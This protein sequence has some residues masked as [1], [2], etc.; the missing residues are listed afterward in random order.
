M[1]SY[2]TDCKS[3][4]CCQPCQLP[5]AFSTL[6]HNWWLKFFD[7]SLQKALVL[8]IPGYTKHQLKLSSILN[9]AQVRHKVLEVCWLDLVYAYG[10][11]HHSLIEFSLRYYHAPSQFLSILQVLLNSV[12]T[13][14]SWET[15]LLSQQKGVYQGD[16]L[17]VVI[18]NTVMNTHFWTLCR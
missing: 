10:S 4:R 15:P 14:H 2:K 5:I 13:T 17:S 18:F 11:V 16:P 1:C 7:T 6:L 9:E 8:T 12:V 3:R